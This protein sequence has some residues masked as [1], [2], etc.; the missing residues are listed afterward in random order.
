MPKRRKTQS[1]KMRVRFL[2]SAATVRHLTL[3]L[4]YSLLSSI[5]NKQGFVFIACKNFR[6]N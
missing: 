6:K 4:I 3:L 1:L 5:E 2:P